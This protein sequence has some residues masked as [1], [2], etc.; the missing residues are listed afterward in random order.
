MLPHDRISCAEVSRMLVRH[1]QLN[2]RA[3]WLHAI[4][5]LSVV[6]N[7]ISYTTSLF[8]SKNMTINT[9]VFQ[10]AQQLIRDVSAASPVL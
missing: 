5:T 10:A 8:S 9:V 3:E 6:L 7:W 1:V 2:E 4:N